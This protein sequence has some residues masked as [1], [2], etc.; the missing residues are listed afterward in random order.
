MTYRPGQPG[1]PAGRTGERDHP[2]DNRA[3]GS[4]FDDEC[5]FTAL[6]VPGEGAVGETPTICLV[7]H[8]H[9][10]APCGGPNR[11]ESEPEADVDA[12]RGRGSRARDRESGAAM[13][14][15]PDEPGSSGVENRVA[16][17][18]FA[19]DL[20]MPVSGWKRARARSHFR[21]GQTAPGRAGH[22]VR[23]S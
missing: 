12:R 23:T 11:T 22:G 20:Q 17:A 16:A 9:H 5:F 15:P 4:P 3:V 7:D 6:G 19:F 10:A 2:A 14:V 8:G 21:I 18:Q 1:V 13:G